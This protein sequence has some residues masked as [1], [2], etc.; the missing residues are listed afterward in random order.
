M[1]DFTR[2]P[3]SHEASI[4][5]PH[6]A[7]QADNTEMTQSASPPAAEAP[8]IALELPPDSGLVLIETARKDAGMESEPAPAGSAATAK[9]PPRTR[10]ARSA[11]ADEPLQMV[12]TRKG[13]SPP[14]TP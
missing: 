12:E 8:K 14:T 11:V 1:Q 4:A 7:T 13:E 5:V 10:P 3:E 9:R 2:A 6:A